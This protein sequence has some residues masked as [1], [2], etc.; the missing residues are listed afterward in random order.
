MLSKLDEAISKYASVLL[1]RG[2]APTSQAENLG[3][4]YAE[5][6]YVLDH[7]LVRAIYERGLTYL[8]VG[9]AIQPGRLVEA[10]GF[11]DLIDPPAQ[12]RWN[13]GIGAAAFLDAHWDR[14]YDLVRPPNWMQTRQAIEALHRPQCNQ[15]K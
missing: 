6:T 12:G 8:E 14:V 15:V 2:F 11:R 7:V 13:L 10:S 1:N 4:G 9:C 3:Y 5:R